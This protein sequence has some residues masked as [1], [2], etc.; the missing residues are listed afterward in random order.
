M[1]K[2]HKQKK[3]NFE[4][5]VSL[6]KVKPAEAGYLTEL[7]MR[8][9]KHWG[10]SDDFMRACRKELT[11]TPQQIKTGELDVMAAVKD[12]VITGFYALAQLS[13]KLFELHALFVE[14]EFI[15]T[16]I[17][18]VLIRHAI[19]RVASQGGESLTIQGDPNAE[20]FYLAAGG[21]PIG[22]KKSGSIPGR[23]LPLFR[24]DIN[25]LF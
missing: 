6:D 12:E 23:Q 16:G 25:P 5:K 10:Y 22:F 4:S 20:R 11:L 21:K 7:A 17:G 3:D 8:S 2:N 13:P 9:K 1:I 19:D 24:I 14:P 18:R 15:G